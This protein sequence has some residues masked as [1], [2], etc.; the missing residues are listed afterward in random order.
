MSIKCH[1]RPHKRLTHKIQVSYNR[2]TISYKCP[3][4]AIHLYDVSF[5]E[6][7]MSRTYP[8]SGIPNDAVHVCYTSVIHMSC[9]HSTTAKQRAEK[10][11]R[12]RADPASAHRGGAAA[13]TARVRAARPSGFGARQ[14]GRRP[15]R[16]GQPG[17]RKCRAP[18]DGVGR[19]RLPRAHGSLRWT[20]RA[21]PN[22]H[23]KTPDTAPAT[24]DDNRASTRPSKRS[25]KRPA[26]AGRN[27]EIQADRES[28]KINGGNETLGM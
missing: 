11:G 28:S 23:H 24:V 7:L 15:W 16:A 20:T 3:T 21:D 13:G 9:T 5:P 14:H 8:G 27:P 18:C 2:S 19:R 1:T 22:P 10:S 6:L 12:A 17:A 26:N 25:S 4:C